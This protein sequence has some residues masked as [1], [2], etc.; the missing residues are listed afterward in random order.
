MFRLPRHVA[1]VPPMNQI[2]LKRAGVADS[3]RNFAHSPSHPA[4]DVNPPNR[5][6]RVLTYLHSFD[7]GGVE[8]VALRL[9]AAWSARGV[10]TLVIVGRDSGSA[11]EAATAVNYRR[12]D[13][14][15]APS[16]R[17][18]LL[19]MIL[20]LPGIIRR[21]R[22]DILFCAGNTY[23]S[24][25]VAMRLLL[26][27]DCPPI[28]AKVSND[29]RR[30]DMPHWL[31][32]LYHR[33]LWLQGRL[34]DQFVGMAPPMHGEI[35]DRMAISADRIAIINDP[36]LYDAE[37]ERLASDC[38]RSPVTCGGRR[39]I[40]IGRLSP[41]KNFA[42]LLEA[43]ARI[44]TPD[45]RLTILGEGPDRQMLAERAAS[46]GIADRVVMPG[47]V[48]DPD[49]WLRDA[50]ILVMSSDYEGVPAVIVEA[51]AAGL[52]VVATDCSV[53]M[54]A[55]LGKGRFGALVPVGDATALATAMATARSGQ[56]CRRSARDHARAFTI[57]N[58]AAAYL[59]LMRSV[60]RRSV[61]A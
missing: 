61:A 43:F 36:V 37:L 34:I 28:V 59:D 6:L 17:L 10:E 1:I 22:P 49:R 50:D 16:H 46:L 24:M 60:A 21:E 11:R 2:V 48:A 5:P 7:P 33:W 29:L 53:S 45:D 52:A 47:H 31:R 15:S 14:R 39:Y 35:A 25:G 55:L 44:A 20:K 40:A 57:E 27:A 23:S 41:Q 13:D 3:R 4:A 18:R 42:L 9:N 38:G 58:G 12:L 54:A 32:F 56:D 8:R 30:R 26:G 51:V 19:W